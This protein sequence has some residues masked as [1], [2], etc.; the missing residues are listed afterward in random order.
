MN[1]KIPE[2]LH[3]KKKY[4]LLIA[5][6]EVS[7]VSW[8]KGNL[9]RIGLFSNDDAGI[10]R[11]LDFLSKNVNMFKDREF[12]LMV[13]IIGEDYRFEKVAH[14]YGKYKTDFHTK[15]MQQ[16]FRGSQFFYVS[17]TRTRR[18]RTAGRLGAFFR[19]VNGN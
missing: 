2:F 11:F 7:M 13:N 1:I 9:E 18:T 10:A 17:G 3:F 19:R 14:L 12:F 16:L 6:N 4:G 8:R 5:D 15:R